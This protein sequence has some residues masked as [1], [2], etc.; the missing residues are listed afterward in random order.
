[1]EPDRHMANLVLP[2]DFALRN[3]VTD[4]SPNDSMYYVNESSAHYLSVGLSALQIV[5]AAVA[6][7]FTR[8]GGLRRILDL[9]CGHG[10]VGRMLRARFP[11]AGLTVCDID[12]DGVDFCAGR[13]GARGV[14]STADFD[15]LD[16]EESY[17]LIWVGSLITHLDAV[18][19]VKFFRCMERC[20]SP[21][22][23][24]IVTSHGRH[25]VDALAA[26]DPSDPILTQYNTLGYGSDA[27]PYGLGQGRSIISRHWFEG[28]FAGDSHGLRSYVERGW[29]ADQ[30]VLLIQQ[31]PFLPRHFDAQRYLDLNPDVAE[32]GADAV[33]HF[34]SYG[35]KEDRVFQ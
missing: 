18:N 20:L 14:Y 35:H 2:T 5:E 33:Q 22:G 12:R 9:P 3:V 24:L 16:L 34:R 19:T 21:E 17:D 28:F 27:D 31:K 13:L 7:G 6:E 11:D 10:R 26:A 29:A 32:Q 23:L 15:G 8:R 1:M 30:D 25:T 4:L